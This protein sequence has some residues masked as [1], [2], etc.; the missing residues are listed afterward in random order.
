[1]TDADK[2]REAF[3]LGFMITREG[4]NGESAHD[5]LM[6]DGLRP[7]GYR[8]KPDAEIDAAIREE[9]AEMLSDP[10]FRALA[11]LAV[12]RVRRGK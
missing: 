3:F 4:F 1:M 8:G 6:P 5:H 11:D 12:A 9:Q 7:D 2:L 10:D